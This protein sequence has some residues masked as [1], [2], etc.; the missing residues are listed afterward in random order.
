M[1]PH[2]AAQ[3]LN[4]IDPHAAAFVSWAG[5]AVDSLYYLADLDAQVASETEDQPLGHGWQVVDHA[6]ARWA[7][8]TAITALDL[9][10]A[11]LGRLL[12]GYPK[13]G[14]HEMD[15]GP[16][17]TTPAITTHPAAGPWIATVVADASYQLV[18]SARHALTH[19]RMTQ[20]IGRS[21]GGSSGSGERTRTYL[22]VPDAMGPVTIEVPHLVAAARDC[23]FEHV[24]RFAQMVD[25]GR[26]P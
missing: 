9:C 15:L 13:G 22:N 19:R 2:D 25:T 8:G 11:A 24:D 18:L 20:T 5:S 17:Q 14:G 1:R 3:A 7:V 12:A 4:G 23:S 26:L 16:A 10:G 6:H 21:F